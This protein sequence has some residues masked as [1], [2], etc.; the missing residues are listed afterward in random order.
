[1][2]SGTNSTALTLSNQVGAIQKWQSSLTSDFASVIGYCE[3]DD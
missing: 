1:V 3:Y 2:C